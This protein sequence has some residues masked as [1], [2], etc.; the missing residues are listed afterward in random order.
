VDSLL[1]EPGH[2][3]QG[4]VDILWFQIGIGIEDL[5]A[6]HPVGHQIH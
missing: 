5:G 1:R 2:I 6:G 4:L 3:V